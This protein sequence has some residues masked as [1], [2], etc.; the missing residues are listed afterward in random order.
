MQACGH[1]TF[2]FRCIDRMKKC[3]LCSKEIAG[4]VPLQQ[5]SSVR[6]S[7]FSAAPVVEDREDS[8]DED[9]AGLVHW[10]TD[11]VFSQGG[12]R[13]V[14]GNDAD[15]KTPLQITEETP[16]DLSPQEQLPVDEA[17]ESPDRIDILSP[18]PQRTFSRRVVKTVVQDEAMVAV[19]ETQ[20]AKPA[21]PLAKKRGRKSAD[22]ETLNHTRLMER[23]LTEILV[24]APLATEPD[25]TSRGKRSDAPSSFVAKKLRTG[26][27]RANQGRLT[28]PAKFRD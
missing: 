28:V 4:W 21:A 3:P 8:D 5:K 15:V 18:E 17:A 13:T 19:V 1:D 24:D 6:P 10:C 20:S 16:K 7:L 27:T 9:S 22:V 25:S 12:V 26:T 23:P 11:D 14:V 2:C